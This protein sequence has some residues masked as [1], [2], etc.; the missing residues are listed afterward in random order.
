MVKSLSPLV[1]NAR[2]LG[3]TGAE[4]MVVG[5]IQPYEI[6]RDWTISAGFPKWGTFPQLALTHHVID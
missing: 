1:Y 4:Y 6:S 5:A 3:K 2:G